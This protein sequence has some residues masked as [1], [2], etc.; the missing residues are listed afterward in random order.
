MST[1]TSKP[2]KINI[3]FKNIF[4][5]VAAFAIPL[6]VIGIVQHFWVHNYYVPSASMETTLYTNDRVL[7]WNVKDH[8][9]PNRGDIVVFEDT[10]GW[11]DKNS[12]GENQYLVKRI[13][14]LPGDT[15]SC[16]SEDG[17]ILVN[18]E[19]YSEP[20]I[21][22]GS[23]EPFKTQTVPEGKMFVLGDNRMFSADSRY[24]IDAGTQFVDLK[25][26]ES[27][28]FFTYWPLNHIGTEK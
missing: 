22:Q 21:V 15:I 26:V 5:L 8:Y 11:L 23:N 4:S 12:K 19:P 16:C 27:T 24:H 13:I 17:R 25:D 20:Y 3:N 6:L 10:N 7:G 28:V 14:G 1:S 9:T 18:G 2:N